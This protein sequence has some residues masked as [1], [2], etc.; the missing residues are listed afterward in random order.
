MGKRHSWAAAHGLDTERRAR[1]THGRGRSLGICAGPSQP[2]LRSLNSSRGRGAAMPA[3]RRPAAASA[4]C[5]VGRWP[6]EL[7][8]A[9]QAEIGIWQA[10]ANSG[11]MPA[12]LRPDG[13]WACPM[14][15]VKEFPSDRRSRLVVHMQTQHAKQVGG[16]ASL[17]QR[18]V[19][20]ARRAQ[21]ALF[22]A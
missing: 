19:I 18:R 20:S 3:L 10:R 15:A 8:A 21:P 2:G 6:P 12:E 16:V 7:H 14:C 13:G 17:K 5:H 4:G 11:D 9:V 22:A 1:P